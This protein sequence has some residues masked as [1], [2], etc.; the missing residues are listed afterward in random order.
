MLGIDP[1]SV[2]LVQ[3]DLP[4]FAFGSVD[5][6]AGAA[7]AVPSLGLLLRGRLLHRLRGPVVERGAALL[8]AVLAESLQRAGRQLQQAEVEVADLRDLRGLIDLVEALAR[9]ELG[10]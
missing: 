10:R 1:G 3:R 5:R 2:E 8:V 7:A 6:A 4:A 9:E